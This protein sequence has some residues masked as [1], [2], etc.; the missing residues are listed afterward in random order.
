M[1]TPTNCYDHVYSRSSTQIVFRIIPVGW[2]GNSIGGWRGKGVGAD[3]EAIVQEEWVDVLVLVG[4][5]IMGG[6][7]GGGMKSY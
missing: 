2:V 5:Y 3:E 1:M 7:G 6:G 4:E